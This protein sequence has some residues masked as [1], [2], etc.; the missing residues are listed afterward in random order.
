MPTG[1]DWLHEA[2][3]YLYS[4]YQEQLNRLDVTMDAT[5]DSVNLDF[6][7]KGLANAATI[8]IDLEEMFVWSV[9]GRSLVVERGYNGT[10]KVPHTE[11]ALIY[12]KPKF[13]PFRIF[14]ALNAVIR[15]LSSPDRGLFQVK[16]ADV[17]WNPVKGF[18]DLP[19]D[20][21]APIEV[22]YYDG[23]SDIHPVRQWDFVRGQ[24]GEVVSSGQALRIWDGMPGRDLRILYKAPFVP[25]LSLDS[26]VATT[27]LE[28]E[29]WDIPPL[30][31]VYRLVPSRD[32]KATFTEAQGEPRRASEVPPGASR[33][34]ASG[35]TNQYEV[36]V[37]QERTR[38][39][40]KYPYVMA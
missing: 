21:L 4:G 26:D 6:D 38:L 24:E 37:A 14:N 34:A 1:H 16:T 40:A 11:G 30:G 23:L 19:G 36:R 25:L 15:E 12:V 35:P 8:A 9:N 10:A 13:P 3:G 18:Y 33:Q 31:A 29:A 5:Q 22:Y 28:P 27:G 39:Q 32:I 20:V 17:P 2:R 7:P